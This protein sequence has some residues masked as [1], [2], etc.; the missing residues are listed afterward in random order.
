MNFTCD[1]KLPGF[2]EFELFLLEET[3]NWPF[4][5]TDE[6]SSKITFSPFENDVE[7]IID[8]DSINVDVNPKQTAD[9]EI[10]PISITFRLITRSEALEQLLEQYANKPCVGLGKLNNDFKKVYGTNL[11]PLYMNYQ[12]NDGTK[13]DGDSFTEVKIKGETRK[14][15][16][17]YTP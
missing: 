14:R 3:D 16:V 15:P 12:V 17:Y 1:E 2:A 8:P 5:L 9:G 11:E 4:V 10:H 6:N 13:I 7:G